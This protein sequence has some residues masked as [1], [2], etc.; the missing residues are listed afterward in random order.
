MLRETIRPSSDL[1]NKYPE[2][3]KSLQLR[4]E[5]AIITV[6][7]RGDT[8]SLGYNTYNSLKAK[9]TVLSSI[10]NGQADIIEGRTKPVEETF[11]DIRTM[12]D[13]ME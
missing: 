8:V 3:S 10:V 4:D 7:G 5:A 11:K 9:I 2:I 13:S 12:L 1:R 6:N